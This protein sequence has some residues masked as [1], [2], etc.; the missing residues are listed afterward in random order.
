MI[1]FNQ[2]FKD[3][4][5]SLL[6]ADV[7]FL[8]V[9]GYALA[10]HG[11]PRGTKDM[12][13]FVEPT[14]ENASRVMQALHAF[15]APTQ[16]VS[17]NDFADPHTVFQIGVP[18]RRIDLVCSIDGVSFEQAWPSR[19]VMQLGDMAVPVIGLQ[20]MLTNKESTG[21]LGDQADA[22]IIR[23]LLAARKPLS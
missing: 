6:A 5:S 3:L 19:Q 2:D 22:E 23:R 10:F 17:A 8:L 12:D 14:P 9:G 7:R 11:H 13:V 21:R 1:P 20:A 4:L 18:P 15:G 16:Q